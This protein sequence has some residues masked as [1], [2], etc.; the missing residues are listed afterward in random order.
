MGVYY[1]K[2]YIYTWRGSYLLA[3]LL[4]QLHK[5]LEVL[6]HHVEQPQLVREARDH[7]VQAAGVRNQ[8]YGITPSAHYFASFL[9]TWYNTLSQSK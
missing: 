9:K 6:D 1:F 3:H 5:A 4:G 7:D 2:I 8:K